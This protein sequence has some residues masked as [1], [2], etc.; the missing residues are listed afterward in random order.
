M[1]LTELNKLRHKARILGVKQEQGGNTE[2]LTKSIAKYERKYNKAKNFGLPIHKRIKYNRLKKLLKIHKDEASTGGRVSYTFDVYEVYNKATMKLEYT[3]EPKNFVS[4]ISDLSDAFKSHIRFKRDLAYAGFIFSQSENGNTIMKNETLKDVSLRVQRE[5][6]MIDDRYNSNVSYIPDIEGFGN[7]YMIT[8]GC[9]VQNIDDKLTYTAPELLKVGSSNHLHYDFEL[10]EKDFV[11]SYDDDCMFEFILDNYP[12]LN[13]TMEDLEKLFGTPKGCLTLLDYYEKFAKKYNIAVYALDINN[14]LLFKKKCDRST[15]THKITCIRLVG[16]HIYPI[17]KKGDIKKVKEMYRDDLIN[18]SVYNDEDPK[19]L[20]SKIPKYQKVSKIKYKELDNLVGDY[21]CSEPIDILYRKIIMRKDKVCGCHNS[22]LAKYKNGRIVEFKYNENIIRFNQNINNIDKLKEILKD[23]VVVNDTDTISSIAN[24]I[25]KEKLHINNINSSY[26]SNTTPLMQHMTAKKWSSVDITDE[27]CDADEYIGVDR[28]KCYPSCMTSKTLQ[29][30][31]LNVDKWMVF[32][33]YDTAEYIDIL[34]Y[35]K[36]NIDDLPYGFYSVE[37]E[38]MKLFRRNGIYTRYVIKL[39]ILNDIE[40][41]C[42]VIVKPSKLLN[43]DYFDKVFNFLYSHNNK[44]SYPMIKQLACTITGL[45]G[46]KIAKKEKHIFQVKGSQYESQIYYDSDKFH[47]YS[48]MKGFTT[49]SKIEVGELVYKT[50]RPLDEN[51]MPIYNQMICNYYCM[52]YKLQKK[53]NFKNVAVKVD[54]IVLHNNTETRNI[55]ETIGKDYKTEIIHPFSKYY[56]SDAIGKDYDLEN[57]EIRNLSTFKLLKVPEFEFH[58]IDDDELIN[59]KPLEERYKIIKDH[60]I[61]NSLWLCGGGG[62]GKTHYYLN[63]LFEEMEADYKIVKV[64]FTN[65]A[66]LQINGSTFHKAFGLDK[67]KQITKFKFS[68]EEKSNIDYIFNDEIGMNNQ[69]LWNHLIFLKKHGVRMLLVGDFSQLPPI[70]DFNN[71]KIKYDNSYILHYLCDGFKCELTESIRVPQEIAD[72]F[73][74]ETYSMTEV[75]KELRDVNYCWFNSTRRR[76]NH[77]VND[78]HVKNNNPHYFN[79]ILE[80]ENYKLYVGCPVISLT[81]HKPN[82]VNS[83]SFKID[84]ISSKSVRLYLCSN[85]KKKITLKMEEFET[86]FTISYCM[87]IYKSQAQTIHQKYT[88]Y[89]FDEL[90]ECERYTAISRTDNINNIL[91]CIG[92]KYYKLN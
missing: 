81:N 84:K 63:P 29:S 19:D 42:D 22:H 69:E 70:Q 8:Y 71:K 7:E 49:D 32:N 9:V 5:F 73:K 61:S 64:S 80:D 38:D 12:E 68:N 26:N 40:F 35:N 41:K 59:S 67:N 83:Q 53:F 30:S 43:T 75:P 16:N 4:K 25:I 47:T 92:K 6:F 72:K 37:T 90:D 14:N 57:R 77:E 52:L 44:E 24:K 87:T 27:D 91:V 46:L 1:T 50:Y 31:G 89:E 82:Y 78:L 13:L 56:Q 39:A 23:Y 65:I 10:N 60:L 85:Y 51:A 58:K 54:C 15:F 28:N 76:I 34:Q 62:Y 20:N 66:S 33:S 18:K 88:I 36:S 11:N 3:D 21:I 2:S 74:S 45:L 79:V 55:L 48:I 17:T 86:N